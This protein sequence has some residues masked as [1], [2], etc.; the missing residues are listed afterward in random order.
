MLDE[1]DGGYASRKLLLT[2]LITAVVVGCWILTAKLLALAPTFETLLGGLLGILAIYCGV[3][4]ASRF[5]VVKSQA[6]VSF[7][8]EVPGQ[9]LPQ[10]APVPAPADDGRTECGH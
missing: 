10:A 8:G 5:A 9:P 1:K 4:V 3:N 2:L 7:Q 6:N